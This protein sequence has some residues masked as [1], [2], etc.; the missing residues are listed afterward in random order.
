[1]VCRRPIA[2][3]VLGHY[4]GFVYPFLPDVNGSRAFPVLV[5]HI[6]ANTSFSI[7]ITTSTLIP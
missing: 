1:V 4:F 7:E 3:M 5:P 2:K 6:V